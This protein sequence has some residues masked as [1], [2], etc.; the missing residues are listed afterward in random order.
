MNDRVS[1]LYHARSGMPIEALGSIR[2]KS[3]HTPFFFCINWKEKGFF[4]HSLKSIQTQ[5]QNLNSNLNLDRFPAIFGF[6]CCLFILLTLTSCTKPDK[7]SAPGTPLDFTVVEEADLPAEL[8]QIIT[9]KKEAPFKLTYNFNGYLYIVQGYGA[10]NT[11]GYSI[12]VDNVYEKE[13]AIYFETTLLGPSK[14]ED[15]KA[16]LSYPYVVVKVEN[17]DMGVVFLS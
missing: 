10:Q 12:S 9:E 13:N 7:D 4:M 3:I 5:T 2:K 1:A 8:S 14:E 15:V 11:G 17:K 16:A 6:L